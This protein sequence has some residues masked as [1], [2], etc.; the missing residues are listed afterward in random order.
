VKTKEMREVV[1][2]EHL[3]AMGFWKFVE[4]SRVGY[5][6]LNV[7]ESEDEWRGKWRAA[8]NRLREFARQGL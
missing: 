7:S 4:E 2:H 8:K 6:F 5:L 1:L 3:E